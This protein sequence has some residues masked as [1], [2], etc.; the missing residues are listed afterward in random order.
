VLNGVVM[1]SE[2]KRRLHEGAVALENGAVAVLRPMLLTA[3][4]AS[5]GF[6]PMAI[7]SSAG[8]EVQRPLATAVIGGMVSS[9]ALGLVL[10]PALL[11]MFLGKTLERAE[12][13]EPIKPNA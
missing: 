10:L 7:A 2:I 3:T 9:T 11:R 8:S 12:L 6:L 13:V 1:A 5:I 4:V